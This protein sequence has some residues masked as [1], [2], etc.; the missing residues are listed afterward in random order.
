VGGTLL[1]RT[2]RGRVR[3]LL[4][5]RFASG[6]R[7]RVPLSALFVHAVLAACLCGLARGRLPPFAYG[8]FALSLTGALVGIPL[9]G[10]LGWLLRRDPAATWVRTL[11]LR[12]RELELARMLHLG[13]LLAALALASAVPAALLAPPE[14][15]PGARLV[16]PLLAIGWVLFVA[17]LLLGVQSLLG[18]RAEGMLVLFQ[19]GVIVLAVVGIVFGVRHLQELARL[20][21]IGAPQAPFLW[22]VPPAWFAAPLAGL[23]S[24]RA[25][26]PLVPT[27]L[28]IAGLALLPPIAAVEWPRGARG[29][30]LGALLAP[31]RALA[32]RLWVRRA[33]RGAFDL[34]YEALPREREVMLRAVPLLGIP[35]AF[36]V[37][38]SSEARAGARSD[39]LALLFFTAGAYLPVLLVHVPVSA[40]P[41]AAWI[42]RT[43]P[44]GARAV[45]EGTIKALALRFLVPLYALLA[46]LGATFGG[47]DVIPRLA[48]P[49]YLVSL[50]CLRCLHPH[51]VAHLPLSTPPESVRFDLDRFGD[52]GGAALVLTGVAVLANRVLDSWPAA[53]LA[54][55]ALLV[56]DLVLERNPARPRA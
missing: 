55:G 9:L 49:G 29:S 54:S 17:A 41:E 14:T 7:E 53:L 19:T 30:W 1:D 38:A 42:L 23:G 48:L 46:L 56:A 12:A 26:L 11:P 24:A 44:V 31:A 36:L 6:S 33:E 39:V 22:L 3:A 52:L 8:V 18:E 13:A 32:S 37:L 10:E 16:L 2:A 5:V 21:A 28:G 50:L 45:A 25:L 27:G 40:T 34:V 20:P 43:A 51:C 4:R 15:E 35:L 47:L